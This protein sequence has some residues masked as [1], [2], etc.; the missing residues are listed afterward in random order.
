MEKIKV[1]LKDGRVAYHK[2][3]GMLAM[4]IDAMLFDKYGSYG[5]TSWHYIEQ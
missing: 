2:V 3:S 1:I 4:D 5:Y